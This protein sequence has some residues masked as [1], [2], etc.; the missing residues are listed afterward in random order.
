MKVVNSHIIPGHGYCT[1]SVFDEDDVDKVYFDFPVHIVILVYD[2]GY[3]SHRPIV[4]SCFC[5][6]HLDSHNGCCVHD[7]QSEYMRKE[8]DLKM[9]IKSVVNRYHDSCKDK[10]IKILGDT[11]DLFNKQGVRVDMRSYDK[12]IAS[13]NGLL[14]YILSRQDVNDISF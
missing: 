7:N 2:N 6:A 3:T 1:M 12:E 10:I 9:V 4:P 8:V 5:S 11:L 13:D 14:Q